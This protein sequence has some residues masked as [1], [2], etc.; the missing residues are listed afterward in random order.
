[1]QLHLDLPCAGQWFA[2]DEGDGALVRVLHPGELSG[3][4]TGPG[5]DPS[6]PRRYKIVVK[7][8]DVRG[9]GTDANVEITLMGSHGSHGPCGLENSR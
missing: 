1:M 9:A 2:R 6:C 7:T 3:Q 8:S 5:S 4:L